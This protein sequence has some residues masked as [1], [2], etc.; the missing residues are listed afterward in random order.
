[1]K[2]GVWLVAATTAEARQREWW[3]AGEERR[4]W[5]KGE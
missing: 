5:K 2:S 1:V 3:K 4:K